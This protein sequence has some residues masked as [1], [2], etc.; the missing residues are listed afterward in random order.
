MIILIAGTTHTGKTAYAQRLLENYD[1]K[2]A[3][4]PGVLVECCKNLYTWLAAAYPGAKISREIPITYH[5]EQGTLYQGFIDML[6]DLPE[7]FVIIDHKS[8]PIASN[9]EKYA[10][11]CAGQLNLYRKAVEAATGRK[12]LQT[13]IHLPNVG[14]CYEVTTKS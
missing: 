4:D 2:D 9:A 10:A 14:K 5:D 8:H 7:G 1:V 12:V 6:L 13:I 3:V 11:S